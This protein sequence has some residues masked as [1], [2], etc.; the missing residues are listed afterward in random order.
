MFIV[1]IYSLDVRVHS[2]VLHVNDV[3]VVRQTFFPFVLFPRAFSPCRCCCQLNC[4]PE[5]LDH[6]PRIACPRFN[7]II[8]VFR[9]ILSVR[10]Y[11]IVHVPI[12]LNVSILR[13]RTLLSISRSTS[14]TEHNVR[15]RVAAIEG[16]L[17]A[18]QNG[19]NNNIFSAET[20]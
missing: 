7:K 20:N 10:H 17:N 16:G 15:L 19:T 18:T 4:S 8:C 11:C 13:R 12:A 9:P 3:N 6:D 5:S 14:A 1:L 2:F